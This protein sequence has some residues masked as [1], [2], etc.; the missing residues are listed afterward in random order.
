ME[1]I[2]PKLLLKSTGQRS[3]SC[4]RVLAVESGLQSCLLADNSIL[5]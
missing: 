2:Q 4:L 5:Y 3:E 1:I